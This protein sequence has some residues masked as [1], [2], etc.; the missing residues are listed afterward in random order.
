MHGSKTDTFEGYVA[1]PCNLPATRTTVVKKGA[2]ITVFYE[3]ETTKTNGQKLKKTR[4]LGISFQEMDGNRIADNQR[5][6]FYCTPAPFQT[7]FMAFQ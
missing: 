3:P 2:V 6:I 5:K 7:Q 1:A 4:I